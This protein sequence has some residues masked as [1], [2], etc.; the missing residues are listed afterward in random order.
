MQSITALFLE[1]FILHLNKETNLAA[2]PWGLHTQAETLPFGGSVP[3]SPADESFRRQKHAHTQ[4]FPMRELI[5]ALI[6]GNTNRVVV[7]AAFYPRTLEDAER[8][9]AERAKAEAAAQG[10][11]LLKDVKMWYLKRNEAISMELSKENPS[12]DVLV[13]LFCIPR[14]CASFEELQAAANIVCP[15][16]AIIRRSAD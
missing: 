7:E 14:L 1:L 15:P 10:N 11:A 5:H 13:A 3:G 16:P 9:Q 4:E 2:K 8:N 6:E 12:V